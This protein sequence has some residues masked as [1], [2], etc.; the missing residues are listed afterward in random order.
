M[1]TP[2][3]GNHLKYRYGICL[4]DKC[5]KCKNKEVQQ[6][7]A[8]KDFVCTNPECGKPLRECPPPPPPINWVKIAC[9]AAGVLAVAG[10]I[11]YFLSGDSS[12]KTDAKPETEQIEQVPT[13]DEAAAEA[14]R[15]DSLQK[16]EADARRA[17]SI[18]QK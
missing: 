14:A 11:W 8:H 12:D 7:L 5:E 1:A 6:I 9:I 4:N 15:L 3:S 2:R 16:A 13:P 18:R 17:D 10:L